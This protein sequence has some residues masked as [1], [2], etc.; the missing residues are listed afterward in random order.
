MLCKGEVKIHSWF[1]D[2]LGK[3]QPG[4]KVTVERD[5]PLQL[6]LLLHN[7][8]PKGSVSRCPQD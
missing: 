8:L 4:S 1:S 7:S 5:L 2:A 6:V 3:I